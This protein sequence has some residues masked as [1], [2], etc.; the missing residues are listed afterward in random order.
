MAAD[1]V[2]APS[3]RTLPAAGIGPF[4]RSSLICPVDG[5]GRGR[6]PAT[7]S[8]GGGSDGGVS[9]RHLEPIFDDLLQFCAGRRDRRLAGIGPEGQLLCPDEGDVGDAHEAQ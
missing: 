6:T 5:I 4:P 7:V 9:G 3:L 1:R 8:T 2:V